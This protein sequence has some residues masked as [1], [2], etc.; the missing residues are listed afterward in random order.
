M[1]QSSPEE[2]FCI[3]FCFSLLQIALALLRELFVSLSPAAHDFRQT[4]LSSHSHSSALLWVTEM[5]CA[6]GTETDEVK[7]DV[8]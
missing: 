5:T 1:L 7:Q 8:R 4:Q 3:I 6:R 2:G